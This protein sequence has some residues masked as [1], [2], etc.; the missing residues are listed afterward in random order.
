MGPPR[1]SISMRESLGALQLGYG[2]LK[3][4]SGETGR[5][6]VPLGLCRGTAFLVIPG[7]GVALDFHHHFVHT[8]HL[9]RRQSRRV[10][11]VPQ[12]SHP[13]L[14]ISRS[15]VDRGQNV[16]NLGHHYFSRRSLKDARSH[17][18]VTAPIS[19]NESDEKEKAVTITLMEELKRQ[20]QFETE[21]ESKTR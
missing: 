7:T 12:E 13:S 10:V 17:L 19:L 8:A 5:L 3:L 16:R 11:V 15:H 2:E 18:G 14:Q 4:A 9:S 20:E 6:G 21:E 1:V